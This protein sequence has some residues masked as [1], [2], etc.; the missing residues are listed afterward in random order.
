MALVNISIPKGKNLV[1]KKQDQNPAAQTLSPIAV[2]PEHMAVRREFRGLESPHL[3][4]PH[5]CA[6][7]GCSPCGLSPGLSSLTACS[8]PWKMLHIPGFLRSALHFWLH[9]LYHQGGFLSWPLR[10]SIEIWPSNSCILHTSITSIV[11]D[12]IYQT[13]EVNI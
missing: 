11:V 9:A 2:Y 13:Q 8:F 3:T 6:L 10:P 7:A 5:L 4:S 1:R 12:K